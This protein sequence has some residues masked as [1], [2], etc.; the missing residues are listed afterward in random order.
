MEFNGKVAGLAATA[1]L[2]NLRGHA[3]SCMADGSL[4]GSGA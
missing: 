2:K 4:P 3:V 1:L